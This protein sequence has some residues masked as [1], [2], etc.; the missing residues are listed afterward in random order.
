MGPTSLS[1]FYPVGSQPHE[2][3]VTAYVLHE[4]NLYLKVN[5]GTFRRLNRS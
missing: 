1:V 2:I 5:T 3:D 4:V